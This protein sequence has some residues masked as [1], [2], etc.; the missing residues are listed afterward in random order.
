M[1][2]HVRGYFVAIDELSVEQLSATIGVKNAAI[3]DRERDYEREYAELVQFTAAVQETVGS[4]QREIDRLISDLVRARASVTERVRVVRL[5][6]DEDIARAANRVEKAEVKWL[7]SGRRF[8]FIMAD[9]RQTLDEERF[10]H[11]RTKAV[12]E[13]SR[14]LALDGGCGCGCG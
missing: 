1:A 7:E 3:L 10:D 8:E 9:L 2:V 11:K 13:R 12:W 14:S 4:A 6:C 5:E